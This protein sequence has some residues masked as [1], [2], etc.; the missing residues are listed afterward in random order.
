MKSFLVFPAG[1][2]ARWLVVAAWFVGI[3]LVFSFNVPGKFADAENN[4]SIS[5][6][7]GDAEAT[8]ALEAQKELTGSE[9][10]PI[11]IVYRRDGG[12]TA[13]DRARVASDLKKLNAEVEGVSSPFRTVEVSKDG[14]AVIVSSSI[15]ATGEADDLLEPVDHAREI[16]SG[17]FNGLDVAL[18]GPAGYGADSVKVFESIN[19]TLFVAAFGLVFVLLILIYRSPF[20]LWLPLI[21]VGFAEIG[22]RA[23]GLGLTELGVTVNGQSSSILSVLVLGAGTDYALLLI[24]RYREELRHRESRQDSMR[25]ALSSAGPAIVASGLTVIAALLCLALAELN[26]TASMGP[27]GAVGIFMAM[28][29]MLTLLP[30]ML[31]IAPRFVFW[32]RVPKEGTGG[33]DAEHGM[34]RRLGDRIAKR[35]RPVWVTAIAVLAVMCLGLTQYD[36][37][38]TSANGFVEDVEAVKGE[39][40]IAESFPDGSNVPTEIV[41]GDPAKSKAVIDAVRQ[42][43]GV[44]SIRQVDGNQD[45]VLLNAIL[46]EEP[47]SPA[48]FDLI[49]GIRDAAHQAGGET[50]LVGGGTAVE[51]DMRQANQRDVK[52]IVPIVLVVVFLILI[53]LLRAVA[54]PVL[55]IGTVVLSFLAALG[56]GFVFSDMVFGFPGVDPS[57]PL[58]VFVFLVALGIDYNIFLMARVREETLA[59]GTREGMLR[60]LAVTGGVIT[61]A[62]IVLA[63]TF[64]VLAVLPLVFLAEMGFTVAF[65]VLL[66]T[67]LVRSILVPALVLDIGPKVWW[68]SNVLMK[69]G[70][71]GPASTGG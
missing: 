33:T 44:A 42:A 67:F 63:G 22:A 14:S 13:S 3:F 31:V 66:D 11:V 37:G 5:Y 18:T 7:P 61:S 28:L 70:K 46:A 1:S 6:L 52:V 24:S 15:T 27:I 40:L 48:A 8:R 41:V 29:S 4:E 30:A 34:W 62:G 64:S 54:A 65:G 47:Y 17:S 21:A 2:R 60:G 36:S 12:L 49:P 51:H 38:L 16:A 59:H 58:Y 19:G 20:L 9:E 32:P 68:P 53:G 57:L 71:T 35:P 45:G 56:V 39:Q 26:S 43:P 25:V 23:V 10:A 69:S 55:L 50:T